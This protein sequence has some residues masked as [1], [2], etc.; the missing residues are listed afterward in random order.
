MPLLPIISMSFKLVS[1]TTTDIPKNSG[2]AL[3]VEKTD[4]DYENLSNSPSFWQERDQK[5]RNEGK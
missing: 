3:T 1:T 2:A 5:E 4:F